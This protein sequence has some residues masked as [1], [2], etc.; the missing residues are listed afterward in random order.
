MSFQTLTC[1]S[2]GRSHEY[3]QRWNLVPP[4][5]Y[6]GAGSNGG[7]PIKGCNGLPVDLTPLHVQ[8]FLDGSTPTPE[9]LKVVAVLVRGAADAEEA[10]GIDELDK[11]V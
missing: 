10:L 8:K 7:P 1:W 2:C 9:Y 6:C 11:E 3:Y 5:P 4:C